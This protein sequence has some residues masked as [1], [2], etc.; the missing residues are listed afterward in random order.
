MAETAVSTFLVFGGTGQTGQHFVSQALAEGHRVRA[1]ARTPSKFRQTNANLDVHQGSI[2]DQID[3]DELLRG[4]DYVVSMLGDIQ[5]QKTRQV[6]T[7]F[8]RQLIPAMRRQGV[9][10][11]LY[12]AGGFSKPPYKR[13]SPVVWALKNTIA[14]KFL[15]QHADNEAVMKYLVDEADDIEWMVHRSALGSDGPSKGTLE[16]SARSISVAPFT[17]CAA[18]NLRTVRDASAIHTCDPSVYRKG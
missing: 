5:L 18:Y 1:L 17:D 11:F 10:R 3:L 2:T 7:E 14:R 15:A 6:N 4:V 16:R 13:L 12:Q 9:T 8:V